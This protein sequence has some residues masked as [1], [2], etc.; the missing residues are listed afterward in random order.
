MDLAPRPGSGSANARHP[1]G[2]ERAERILGTPGPKLAA[3]G[4]HPWVWDAAS[5]LWADEHYL[6][7]VAA[8]ASLVDRNLQ[9]KLGRSDVSGA[10]LVTAAFSS[11][12]PQPDRPRLRVP[13]VE[14]GSQDRTSRHQGAMNFG[15]GCMQAIGN[16]PTM[17]VDAAERVASPIFGE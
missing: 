14:P 6:D 3:S 17:Q 12:D 15:R 5:G 8:A 2:R 10:S 1:G 9:A 16:P 11:D 7:A 13:D 4:L